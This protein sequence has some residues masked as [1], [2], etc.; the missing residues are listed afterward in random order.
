[1]KGPVAG[2]VLAAALSA[3]GIPTPA[4]AAEPVTTCVLALTAEFSPGVGA[5]PDAVAFTT[6]GAITCLG[7][8]AGATDITSAGSYTST[9]TF[10]GNCAG[11]RGTETF[12][13]RFDRSTGAHTL[14]GTHEFTTT[15]PL[16]SGDGAGATARFQV[17]P[18][19]GGACVL[20]PVTSAAVLG[21]V[22]L[23]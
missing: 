4:A 8:V 22:F 21:E 19:G 17:V 1:V 2:T 18:L 9:G 15:G 10:H 20:G 3:A 11:G 6:K 14:T 23:R 16:G 13:A 7:P 5:A 12:T